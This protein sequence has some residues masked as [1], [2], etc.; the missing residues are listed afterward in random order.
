MSKVREH[1]KAEGILVTIKAKKWTWAGHVI[2]RPAK[3]WTT[4]VTEWQPRYCRSQGRQKARWRGEI[5]AFVGA[6]WSTLISDRE[7]QVER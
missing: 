2:R 6:E 1:T 5:R 3:R 4:K 7:D